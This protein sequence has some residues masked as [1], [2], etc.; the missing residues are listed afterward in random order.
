VLRG[1]R[2]NIDDTAFSGSQHVLTCL[3][4]HSENRTEVHIDNTLKI[5]IRYFRKFLLLVDTRIV[6]EYIQLSVPG[7]DFGHQGW[8]TMQ[9]PKVAR[10]DMAARSQF[11]FSEG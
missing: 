4:R 7:Y 3:A 6:D 8:N 9:L 1:H 2:A 5:G 10:D 11:L